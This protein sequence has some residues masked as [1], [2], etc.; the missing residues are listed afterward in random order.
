MTPAEAVANAH[1][2]F[3]HHSGWAP[4]DPDTLADWARDE[5]DRAPDDCQ[6]DPGG[7]CDHGLAC[8]TLILD[9]LES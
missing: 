9:A 6:T 2:W 7:W 4:P 1:E 3:H 8:W 5:M